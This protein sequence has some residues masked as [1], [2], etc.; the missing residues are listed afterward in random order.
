M[1]AG[2]LRGLCRGENPVLFD[3]K[4]LYDRALLTEQNFSFLRL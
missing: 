4:S 3:V 1:P 2:V